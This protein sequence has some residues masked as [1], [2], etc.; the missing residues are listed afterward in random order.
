MVQSSVP[1]IEASGLERMQRQ[2]VHLSATPD[3][4]RRV[5]ARRGWHVVLLVDAGE[6]HKD[7]H[8]FFRSANEVWLTASVP[9]RYIDVWGGV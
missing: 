6:M 3:A 8:L 9:W 5:G 1:G 2:H 7:G 4:A